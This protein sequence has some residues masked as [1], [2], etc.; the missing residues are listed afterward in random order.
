MRIYLFVSRT[1]PGVL[2]FTADATGENLPPEYAPW[3]ASGSGAA[4]PV[5]DEDSAIAASV[6]REGYFLMNDRV[7]RRP[8]D[9]MH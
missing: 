4:V 8:G 2:A 6:R 9:R 7:T 5:G 1:H 3:Q